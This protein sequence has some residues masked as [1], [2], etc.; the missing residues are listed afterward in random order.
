M[1]KTSDKANGE[2]D[3]VRR[4]LI[5]LALTSLFILAWQLRT[6]LLMVFGAIVVAT[7]FRSF[8]DRLCQLLRCSNKTATILSIVIILGL[9]LTM[10]VIF[11]QHVWQQI[12]SLREA[13]P[14]AWAALEARMGDLGLGDQIK[15]LAEGMR[16]PGGSSF[17]AFGRTVL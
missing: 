8:A 1:A 3:F 2:H 10:I 7:V 11:G 12:D 17:S 6:L 15:R 9:V 5:V 4:V 14:K 13:I 16:A